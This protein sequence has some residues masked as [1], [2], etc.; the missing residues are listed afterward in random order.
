M[1]AYMEHSPAMPRG[2]PINP[3]SS[4]EVARRLV[5]LRRALGHTQAFLAGLLDCAPQAWA[6][7]EAG[8]RRISVDMALKLCAITGVS[9][10]WVYRGNMAMLP[11]ELAE[12]IQVEMRLEARPPARSVSRRR[13]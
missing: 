8:D 9:L 4:E 7:Y 6:N 10:D 2:N 3:A 11:T 13:S 1:F 5:L 12:K